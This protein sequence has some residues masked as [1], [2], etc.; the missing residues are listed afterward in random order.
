MVLEKISQQPCNF[1][2]AR[3]HVES[4]RQ[5]A[6]ATFIDLEKTFDTVS[7]EILLE[8]LD[9]YDIRGISNDW[10]RCYL[11]D[12][13]QFASLNSFNTDYKTIKYGVRQG[14]VIGFSLFL[15]SFN[16]LNIAIKHSQHTNKHCNK[17]S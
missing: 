14:L 7:Y 1:K 17:T 3:K 9:H 6:C 5:I 10:F 11:S 12:R 4:S 8:K 16:D 15:I 13:S 2:F